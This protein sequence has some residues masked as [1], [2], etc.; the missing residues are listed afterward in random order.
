[1]VRA[2]MTHQAQAQG[3][4]SEVLVRAVRTRWNTVTMVLARALELRSILFNVC[5]MA[6]FN[7]AQGVRLHRFIVDE[8]DWPILEQLYELL[9]V[10]YQCLNS[11][12][13][14]LTL[15]A[16]LVTRHSLKR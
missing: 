5:N 1:M 2:E 12:I 14:M 9:A 16:I 3:K 6:E 7:K 10:H 8:G 4:K 11:E 15:T 13:M